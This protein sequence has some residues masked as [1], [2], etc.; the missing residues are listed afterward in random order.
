MVEHEQDTPESTEPP[1]LARTKLGTYIGRLLHVDT[2]A[3]LRAKFPPSPNTAQPRRSE[4]ADEEND[5]VP[6]PKRIIEEQA[7]F[8]FTVE[9]IASHGLKQFKEQTSLSDWVRHPH[10]T[11]RTKRSL[12][13]IDVEWRKAMSIVSAA[14]EPVQEPVL[15]SYLEPSPQPPQ[16]SDQLPQ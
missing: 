15:E 7:R 1:R 8:I 6:S 16:P 10:K 4:D 11:W 13:R 14:T 12:K 3:E 2:A 5:S 9:Q